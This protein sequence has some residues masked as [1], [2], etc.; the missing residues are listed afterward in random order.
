MQKSKEVRGSSPCAPTQYM[1]TIACQI[2]TTPLFGVVHLAC[3]GLPVCVAGGRIFLQFVNNRVPLSFVQFLWNH[4]DSKKKSGNAHNECL[5][6]ADISRRI[7]Q[8]DG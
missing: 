4:G 3:L 2:K 1:G 6:A 7:Q 8:F 5:N